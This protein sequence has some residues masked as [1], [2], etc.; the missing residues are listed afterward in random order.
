MNHCARQHCDLEKYIGD[1]IYVTANK[2]E[3]DANPS[4]TLKTLNYTHRLNHATE[5]YSVYYKWLSAESS[6]IISA[7]S[8]LSLGFKLQLHHGKINT[9][10]KFDH[11]FIGALL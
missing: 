4:P 11:N 3:R 2:L 10:P 1:V 7:P 9:L 5:S 8:L 6:C